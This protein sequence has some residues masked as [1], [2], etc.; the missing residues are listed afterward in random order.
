MPKGGGEMEMPAQDKEG[1]VEEL[2]GLQMELLTGETLPQYQGFIESMK[3][4]ALDRSK[5]RALRAARHTEVDRLP[6]TY[7]R[8][9]QKGGLF[10]MKDGERVVGFVALR[11][12][13]EDRTGYVERIWHS[14]P[15]HQANAL[16]Q[17]LKTS[18]KYFRDHHCDKGVIEAPEMSRELTRV[19][20]RYRVEE[21]YSVENGEDDEPKIVGERGGK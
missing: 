10:V 11:V 7:L 1:A 17:M 12:H 4:N 2:K 5:N 20:N 8:E 21:F 6:H 3:Y 19:S 14:D 18:E 13:P 16:A 9:S 15:H